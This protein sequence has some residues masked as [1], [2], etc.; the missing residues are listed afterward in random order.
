MKPTIGR[1]VIYHTTEQERNFN[2]LSGNLQY[3]LPAIIVAVHSDTCVNLKVF[4]DGV[5]DMWKT[6]IELAR[7][8]AKVGDT[9]ERLGAPSPE[10][11]WSW[12][13]INKPS[14]QV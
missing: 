6:S 9:D 13:V 4:P 1:V 2:K 11:C 12:P 3:E 7:E 8:G 10:G 5:G 14:V